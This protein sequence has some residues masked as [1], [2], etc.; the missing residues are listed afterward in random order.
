MWFHEH[1]GRRVV[2]GT[3]LVAVAGV[4]LAS[5]SLHDARWGALM[6]AGACLMWAVDNTVTAA[7]DEL[8]P[9]HITFAKGAIAGS[10][11]LV[12]GLAL[13][14]GLASVGTVAWALV[15]G[16]IGYG[17]SI[18]LWVSGARELGAARGQLVFALAPFIGAALS[19]TVLDEKVETLQLVAL[20]IALVGV[21]FVTRTAHEHQHEH[22][23]MEHD[24]AH[25]HP[26]PHHTHEHADGFVGRH[27]HPHAHEPL[28]HSHPHVPDLHHHH[29]H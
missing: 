29:G 10:A 9:A 3:A 13:A 6:V 22:G 1:L 12:L 8:R 11:N 17:A 27:Q 21:G 26:D 28:V 16:A 19:W 18:T 4:L 25:D 14:D 24:H 7:L 2:T 23:A 20:V 5:G 15:V